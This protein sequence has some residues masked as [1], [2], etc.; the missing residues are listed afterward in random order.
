M[1]VEVDY[2]VDKIYDKNFKEVNFDFKKYA[3]VY[4]P[5]ELDKDGMAKG[6][7]LDAFALPNGI[8]YFSLDGETKHPLFCIENE[9]PKHS[10]Y[11]IKSKI[12]S[13]IKDD[14]YTYYDMID[15]T[16]PKI[17]KVI[18]FCGNNYTYASTIKEARENLEKLLFNKYK[19]KIL[20]M[21][22]QETQKAK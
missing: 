5:L 6:A 21:V 11:I 10:I 3:S 7:S 2:L 12:A 20:R 8:Y 14:V 1:I 17:H 18:A 19:G 22:S 13:D 15:N 16:F 4:N 9:Y